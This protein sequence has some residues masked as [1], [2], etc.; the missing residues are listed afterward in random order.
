MLNKEQPESQFDAFISYRRKDGRTLAARLRDALEHYKLPRSIRRDRQRLKI[1]LDTAYERAT[2]DFYENVILPA[3]KRS[4]SIIVIATLGAYEARADGQ[5]NWIE[6][7]IEDFR[8]LPQRAEGV[9]VVCGSGAFEGVT[10]NPVDCQAARR[11]P[12]TWLRPCC[13]AHGERDGLGCSGDVVRRDGG[14]LRRAGS[15][16]ARTRKLRVTV[17]SGNKT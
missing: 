10:E 16:M 5:R 11:A 13:S 8:K 9:R 1:Y 6:R 3:L 17:K 4:R 14:R 12:A 7:E 2:E 15:A